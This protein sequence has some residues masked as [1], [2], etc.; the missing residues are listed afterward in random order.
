MADTD[1]DFQLGEDILAVLANS[2]GIQIELNVLE[3]DI[4]QHFGHVIGK[5]HNLS[6]SQFK[7]HGSRMNE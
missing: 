7:P 1:S 6:L 2:P 3:L 4:I 5:I